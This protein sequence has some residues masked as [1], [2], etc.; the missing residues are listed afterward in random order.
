MA[1][2]LLRRGAPQIDPAARLLTLHSTQY[3]PNGEGFPLVA[4]PMRI[5]LSYEWCDMAR[6]DKL[7]TMLIDSFTRHK[8]PGTATPS[9]APEDLGFHLAMDVLRS[10]DAAV[11]VV[12]VMAPDQPVVFVNAAFCSLT[13]YDRTQALGRNCRF[14]QNASTD[15]AAVAMVR[16]GI[17]AGRPV[18]AVLRNQRRDGS[19]FW[20]FLRLMPL[21]QGDGRITHYVGFQHELSDWAVSAPIVLSMEEADADDALARFEQSIAAALREQA[22]GRERWVLA[23]LR[24]T[25]LSA[26]AG[27]PLPLS[28]RESVTHCLRPFVL[29]GVAMHFSYGG[30]VAVLVPVGDDQTPSSAVA[31]LL[32]ALQTVWPSRAGMAELGVDGS[33]AQTLL[34][35]AQMACARAIEE[36]AE[37]PCYAVRQRNVHR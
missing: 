11:S 37:G 21:A 1:C 5:Q 15:R 28:Q 29:D 19:S 35:H 32:E 30:S 3:R 8:S 17:A 2:V 24:G 33:D 9:G 34:K 27:V 14:L 10:V 7:Q 36:A 22:S 4:L 16:D 31:P 13:G 23:L 25:V 18:Q 26:A 20:N 6:A 12:D